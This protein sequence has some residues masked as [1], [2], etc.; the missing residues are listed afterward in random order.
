MYNVYYGHIA[1]NVR[2]ICDEVYF[3][4]DQIIQL[5]LLI[6]FHAIVCRFIVNYLHLS[7][8]VWS[9]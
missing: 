3:L 1:T 2:G 4:I 6:N 5:S 9:I 7:V 8:K